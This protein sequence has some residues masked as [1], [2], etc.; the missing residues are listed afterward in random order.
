MV[1]FEPSLRIA[2]ENSGTPT[3]AIVIVLGAS[4]VALLVGSVILAICIRDAV[5]TRK[6]DEGTNATAASAQ[7]N[8]TTL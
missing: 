8:L 1:G 3:R 4:A 6:E 5:R 7:E 2:T